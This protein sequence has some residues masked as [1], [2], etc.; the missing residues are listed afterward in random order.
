[1]VVIWFLVVAV[2]AGLLFMGGVMYFV[3]HTTIVTASKNGGR[4][5]APFGVLSESHN[6]AQLAHSLGLP[7]YPGATGIR[8]TQA[9]LNHSIVVSFEFHSTAAPRAIIHYYHIRYPDAS[10]RRSGAGLTLVQMN[11]RDTMTLVAEPA[12]K[13]TRILVSDIRH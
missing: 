12:G 11:P 4:V 10:V 6:P 7:L 8:G 9:E 5:E 1:M 2:V 13:F 3:H